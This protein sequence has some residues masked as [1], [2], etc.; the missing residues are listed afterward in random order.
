MIFF[1]VFG[2]KFLIFI[3]VFKLCSVFFLLFWIDFS[4]SLY[5]LNIIS[6]MDEELRL[7]DRV[8]KKLL[9]MVF[10]R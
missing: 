6:V 4:I 10:D 7:L 1:V 8:R 9:F 3:I 5:M 2:M